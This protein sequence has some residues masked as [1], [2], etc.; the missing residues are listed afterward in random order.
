M[1]LKLSFLKSGDAS[2]DPTLADIGLG[3][4]AINYNNLTPGIYFRVSDGNPLNDAITKI[5]PAGAIASINLDGVVR[6]WDGTT[7]STVV[8]EVVNAPT[9]LAYKTVTDDALAIIGG[10]VSALTNKVGVLEGDQLQLLGDVTQIRNDLDGNIA[11]TLQ[12]TTDITDLKNLGISTGADLTVIQQTLATHAVDIGNNKTDIDQLSIDE[13]ALTQRV[14]DNE[15]E[16]QIL[17]GINI[18]TG[19]VQE[20]NDL[21]DV[22]TTGALHTPADNEVLTWDQTL[23]R[24]VPKPTNE[25]P[26]TDSSDAATLNGDTTVTTP[27]WVQNAIA[28][29]ISIL[30]TALQTAITA[31]DAANTTQTTNLQ[32]ALQQ[33]IDDLTLSDL[34]DTSVATPGNGEVLTWDNTGGNWVPAAIPSQARALEGLTNVNNALPVADEILKYISGEWDGIVGDLTVTPSPTEITLTSNLLPSTVSGVLPVVDGTNAGLMVPSD[35]TKLD[36]IDP[37]AGALLSTADRTKLD[38]LDANLSTIDLATPAPSNGDV[39]TFNGTDWAAATPVSTVDLASAPTATEVVVTSSAGTNATI[40]EVTVSTA[41]TPIAGVIVPAD[42][43]KLN[44]IDPETAVQTSLL[45]DPTLAT[46]G[47]HSGYFLLKTDAG[48]YEPGNISVL[49]DL[50]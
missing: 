19:L 31:G 48:V 50:P 46:A 27:G 42:K 20:M 25:L 44:A 2:K 40:A 45:T 36:G 5:T 15:V 37:S 26:V 17:K 41:T 30:D 39:L 13:Q 8:H 14:S 23:S 24:W 7:I 35:K 10:N 28:L 49:P 38:G 21:T 43:D 33:N 34:D 18:G 32:T 29:D 9:F 22:T 3:E 11:T 6:I 12:L 47:A 16:I 4:I 1:S